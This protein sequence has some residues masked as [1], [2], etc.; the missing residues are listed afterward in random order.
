MRRQRGNK[1]FSLYQRYT[2]HVHL[3]RF[4]KYDPQRSF[5][6]I[7]SLKRPPMKIKELRISTVVLRK[8]LCFWYNINTIKHLKILYKRFINS[9]YLYF[10]FLHFLNYKLDSVLA[11]TK[12]AFNLPRAWDLIKLRIIFIN[13]IAATSNNLVLQSGDFISLS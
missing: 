13:N 9:Y 4:A 10:S 1:R 12:L 2:Y 8:Y 7:F 3:R 5:L 6:F 11:V